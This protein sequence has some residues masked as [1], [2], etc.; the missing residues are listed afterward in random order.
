MASAKNFQLELD[1]GQAGDA[2]L[3]APGKRGRKKS[4]RSSMDGVL[5]QFGKYDDDTFNLDYTFPL[6]GLQA[7]AIALSTTGWR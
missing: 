5:L 3:R 2:G 7:F 4:K 1:E 6:C